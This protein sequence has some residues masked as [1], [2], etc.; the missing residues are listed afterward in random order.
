M[1]Q[2]VIKCFASVYGGTK[3]SRSQSLRDRAPH[4]SPSGEEEED[5]Y[6]TIPSPALSPHTDSAP[7]LGG[8]AHSPKDLKYF[9]SE[10]SGFVSVF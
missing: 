8:E 10:D 3:A 4:G 2:L 7:A 6:S 5:H 9:S 1:P